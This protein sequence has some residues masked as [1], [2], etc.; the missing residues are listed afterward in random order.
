MNWL[1]HILLSKRDVE[2]QIG[3]F[4]ADPMKGNAWE[5]ASASIQ[6]GMQMHKAIDIFTDSHPI[7]SQ[8]KSRLG[9]K[10][11]LKGVVIDL[12]YDHYLSTHWGQYARLPL[13]DFLETFY[14]S[15]ARVTPT[16]PHPAKRHISYLVQSDMLASYQTF[17]GF[18]EALRR[19]DTRLSAQIK[20][21]DSM[22]NYLAPIE[23]HYDALQHDFQA[24]FPELIAFFKQHELGSPTDNYL[25]S[26]PAP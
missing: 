11:Y 4:L 19:I 16:Y 6:H 5:G 1:A 12:L 2:Y 26:N 10:G 20:A 3:N 13:T 14:A 25:I 21:K 24:Y 23:D 9:E 8:S 22:L 17:T 15:A 18:H 7:V